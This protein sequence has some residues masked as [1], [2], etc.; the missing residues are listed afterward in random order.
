MEGLHMYFVDES[1]IEEVLVY[2]E[3]LLQELQKH[4]YDSFLEK[5]A[6]ERMTLMI[7]ELII[8][9]GNMLIVCFIMREAGSYQHIINIL[10]DEKVIPSEQEKMYKEIM[11]LRNMLVKEYMQV[12]HKM[13]QNTVL[14]H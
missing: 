4:P 3:R 8:D 6:L 11:R 2:I 13:R 7:I 9:V 10:I 1:K 5:L 12:D 14:E